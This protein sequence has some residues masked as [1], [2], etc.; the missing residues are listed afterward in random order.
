MAINEIVER[1]EDEKDFI[2][3]QSLISI[4]TGVE[5]GDV[6]EAKQFLEKAVKSKNT[7]EYIL[8]QLTLAVIHHKK[9]D[10]QNLLTRADNALEKLG[11]WHPHHHLYGFANYCKAIGLIGT[12]DSSIPTRQWITDYHLAKIQVMKNA[13]FYFLKTLINHRPEQ[14]FFYIQYCNIITD[15]SMDLVSC[16][17]VAKKVRSMFKE[18]VFDHDFSSRQEFHQAITYIDDNIREWSGSSFVPAEDAEP[19]KKK[20]NPH[21]VPYERLI[22]MNIFLKG[23]A[24]AGDGAVHIETYRG[25]AEIVQKRAQQFKEYIAELTGEEDAMEKYHTGS[26]YTVVIFFRENTDSV[27]RGEGLTY[28]SAYAAAEEG[29]PYEKTSSVMELAKVDMY[30]ILREDI[31]DK[32][33]GE[34]KEKTPID[35][36]WSIFDDD[37]M[38]DSLY[39]M[40]FGE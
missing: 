27:S 28:D 2:L 34:T 32:L 26:K 23:I 36:P 13:R 12:F 3:F 9:E 29:F 4:A 6:P 11:N 38:T 40:V 25:K 8:G 5:K 14:D 16:S 24:Y 39:R 18:R 19:D 17:V 1:T 35:E 22:K 33:R 21:P 10:Y 37:E 20:W 31:A 7:I 30:F 15:N